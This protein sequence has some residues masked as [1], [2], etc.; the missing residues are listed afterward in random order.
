[1]P[2]VIMKASLKCQSCV[3]LCGITNVSSLATFSLPLFNVSRTRPIRIYT[4]NEINY[5]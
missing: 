1:M 2:Y 3:F 5:L 4:I